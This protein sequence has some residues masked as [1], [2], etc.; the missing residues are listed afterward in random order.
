MHIVAQKGH[1]AYAM[2]LSTQ[3]GIDFNL[4]NKNARSAYFLAER[5]GHKHVTALLLPETNKRSA[6]EIAAMVAAEPVWKLISTGVVARISYPQNL[7][8]CLTEVFDRK[9]EEYLKVTHDLA[10]MVEFVESKP[11]ADM[12]DKA[13]LKEAFTKAAENAPKISKRPYQVWAVKDK[14][15]VM[16]RRTCLRAIG[17]QLTE[18]FDFAHSFLI[19]RVKNIATNIEAQ[20][21]LDFAKVAD[22]DGLLE[23]YQRFKRLQKNKADVASPAAPRYLNFLIKNPA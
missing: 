12:P 4:L 11:F 10:T 22:K 23:A 2:F 14:A 9:T 15:G 8:L 6:A 16:E 21:G 17:Y 13:L 18:D 7:G 20:M 3:E 1:I 5:A 19:R